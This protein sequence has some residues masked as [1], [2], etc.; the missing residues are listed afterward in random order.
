MPEDVIGEIPSESCGGSVETDLVAPDVSESPSEANPS[1]ANLSEAN[2]Q[3]L[4]AQR[5]AEFIYRMMLEESTAA[6][7]PLDKAPIEP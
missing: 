5:F 6:A 3:S 4:A 2:P 7:Q 1:E